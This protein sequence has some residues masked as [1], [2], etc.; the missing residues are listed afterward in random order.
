VTAVSTVSGERVQAAPG[1]QPARSQETYL[2][3]ERAS[4]FASRG[5]P[6][7]GHVQSY[8]G[9]ASLRVDQWALSG[10][11]SIE[12]DRVVLARAPG[13]IAYRFHARDLHLVLG[14]GSDG[15]PLRFRVLVDG[16]PPGADHGTDVDAQGRGTVDAHRLYQLVRRAASDKDA[17]FEIEF[18]DADAQAYVFTFG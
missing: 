18:L 5:Q 17:L 14:P 8:A 6:V 12:S 15:R 1:P 9:A 4:G 13:R 11:W 2:G 16:K 10:D 7:V 3:Y